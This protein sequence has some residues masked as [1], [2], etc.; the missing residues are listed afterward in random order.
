MVRFTWAQVRD[1]VRAHARIF[2]TA[3]L[4][5]AATLTIVV[6]LDDTDK[7]GQP[8]Q[9]T[10]VVRAADGAPVKVTAPAA[11]VE[12]AESSSTHEGQRSEQPDGVPA[13]Q[14]DQ[15]REQQEQLAAT[16]QL[17]VVTPDAAPEQAG[18]VTRL[19]GNFSSRRGVRPR[20]FVLHYTV[21]P[22]RPGWSDVNAIVSLFDRPAF[23]ASSNYVI[24]REG[25]CALIVRESDK[26]WTQAALNPV[27]ISVEQINTGR[28]AN[29]A[30]TAGLAKLARVISDSTRRWE[31]PVQRGL[32]Q[33][34]R[35]VRP[36]IVDHAQ[37]GACGGGHTD[38][39]PFST[40]A[41]IAAVR[42]HRAHAAQAARVTAVDRRT[43]RK[44]TH[45]R[46]AGRPKGGLWEQRSV[47]RRR[48]LD[49][50]MVKCT[51]AGP[52]KGHLR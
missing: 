49:A 18:C 14:L 37:L 9:V 10:I 17:P 48:A 46:Q 12:Q 7:N 24:D 16:D 5:V 28:E 38:I 26:A 29:Y 40:A 15:A 23:A 42:A 52:V 31:I 33:G 4:A 32:V 30:G 44:L 47:R 36:G 21:S 25:N 35:V 13:Q 19:V 50:R 27:A 6:T 2:T 34:C 22:N 8:D 45:W 1:A 11:V 39:I 43:C 3:L 41:V 51:P 20:L